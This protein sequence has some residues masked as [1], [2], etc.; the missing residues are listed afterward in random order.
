VQPI[1]SINLFSCFPSFSCVLRD[2]SG[3]RHPASSLIRLPLLQ[4]FPQYHA[5]AAV[6]T[7]GDLFPLDVDDFR[8]SANRADN[9]KTFRC[10]S[11]G[12]G[13]IGSVDVNTP[14]RVHW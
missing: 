7:A 2:P 12:A 5:G 4:Q 11:L 1:Q 13:L 10:G 9:V 8:A 14:K 3:D 6:V